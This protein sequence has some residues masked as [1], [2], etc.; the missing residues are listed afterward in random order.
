VISLPFLPDLTPEHIEIA[1]ILRKNELLLPW[2]SHIFNPLLQKR[3]TGNLYQL[4]G[5]KME[6]SN[7]LDPTVQQHKIGNGV[8]SGIVEKCVKSLDDNEAIFD[9][10]L[11]SFVNMFN[12]REYGKFLKNQEYT[13]AIMMKPL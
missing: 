4:S 1:D 2:G 9:D 11:S 12:K 6:L 13:G 7:K 10:I 8:S 3:L 5:E